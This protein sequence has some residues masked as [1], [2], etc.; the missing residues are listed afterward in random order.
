MTQL[1]AQ[2]T[3]SRILKSL[4]LDEIQ[5][6]CKHVGMSECCNEFKNKRIT[7]NTLFRVS[8][9][10]DFIKY[11]IKLSDLLSKIKIKELFVRLSDIKQN[12]NICIHNYCLSNII[13]SMP[14]PVRTP[15]PIA[16]E[17]LHDATYEQCELFWEAIQARQLTTVQSMLA[18][19]SNVSLVNTKDTRYDVSNN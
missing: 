19:Y 8:N 9:E 10:T 1:N 18:K 13:H 14:A 7:G 4:T 17:V 2:S 15:V 11:N 16:I 6:W 12:Q 5:V 3:E